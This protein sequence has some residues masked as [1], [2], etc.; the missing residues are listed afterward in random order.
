MNIKEKFELVQSARHYESYSLV[1]D[2]YK[3]YGSDY[4]SKEEFCCKFI[5]GHITKDNKC[6]AIANENG[7]YTFDVTKK[8]TNDI[9]CGGRHILEIHEESI[10]MIEEIFEKY[11]FQYS[12]GEVPF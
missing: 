5:C 6:K 4:K 9:N 2:L 10:Q 3:R 11:M 1:S 8:E 12:L 7:D